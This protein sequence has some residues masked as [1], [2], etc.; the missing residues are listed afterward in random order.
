VT[1]VIRKNAFSGHPR[2]DESMVKG[3]VEL[4]NRELKATMKGGPKRILDNGCPR[5]RKEKISLS[6]CHSQFMKGSFK[7]TKAFAINS[8]N[9]P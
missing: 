4:L 7:S 8:A 5:L 6:Q 2:D 9:P 1:E 3:L